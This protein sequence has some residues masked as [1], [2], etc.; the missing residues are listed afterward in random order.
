MGIFVY[1]FGRNVDVD[2]A[3]DIWA[4]GGTYSFPTTAQA[5]TIRSANA[6][7]T[8]TGAGARTV[9]IAGLDSNY[10]SI[11]E[12]V[13]LNGT[14]NVTCTNQFLRINRSNVATAGT[15]GT[16]TGI[17]RIYHGATV[18]GHIRAGDGQTLQTQ[19][20]VPA[21]YKQ[22][23]I[24][25]WNADVATKLSTGATMVLMAREFGGAWRVRDIFGITEAAPGR[26]EYG[27]HKAIIFPAKTDVKIR[28]AAV[29]AGN[30]DIAAGFIM[31]L[32]AL[33]NN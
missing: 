25:A 5:T 16:N 22:G 10:M 12:T 7:D 28:A 21:N 19:Y 24:K 8:S 6:A 23:Y 29:A 31:E 14:T 20:T 15:G 18:L 9:T 26:N 27:E 11:S 4:E 3:E 32:E 17:L 2:A 33:Q 30:T 1:K 13:A